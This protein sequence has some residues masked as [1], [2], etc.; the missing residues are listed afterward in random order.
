MFW[1]SQMLNTG[2]KILFWPMRNLFSIFNWEILVKQF[3]ECLLKNSWKNVVNSIIVYNCLS[4]G[5][6]EGLI[7][8]VTLAETVCR[9]QMKQADT[10]VLKVSLRILKLKSYSAQCVQ[11]NINLRKPHFPLVWF[12]KIYSASFLKFDT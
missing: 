12:T 11:A 5:V 4:T 10:F 7:E 3:V 8:V 9:I 1:F 2:K 6:N